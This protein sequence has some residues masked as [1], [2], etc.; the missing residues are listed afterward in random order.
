MGQS[1]TAFFFYGFIFEDYV[2]GMEYMETHY[3]EDDKPVNVGFAG[4]DNWEIY[5]AYARDSMVEGNP[6]EPVSDDHV[7]PIENVIEEWTIALEQFASEGRIKLN[8]DKIKIGWHVATH[9]F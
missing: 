8:L 6:I 4:G 5:F 1:L 3:H 7:R 2:D 9:V